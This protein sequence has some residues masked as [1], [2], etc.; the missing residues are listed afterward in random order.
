M[1]TYKTTACQEDT[2]TTVS[3]AAYSDEMEVGQMNLTID[4]DGTYIE[5]IDVI[6]S[7]RGHGFGTE[8]LQHV[9]RE[10]DNA[11][12]APDNADAKRLYERIG[13]EM[14]SGDYDKYGYAIDQGYGVYTI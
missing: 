5:R 3:V 10:Y 4:N 14:R 6:E 11:F 13:C 12:L 2:Y 9:A 7:L 1:L 8:M